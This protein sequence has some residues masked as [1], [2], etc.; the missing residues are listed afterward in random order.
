MIYNLKIHYLKRSNANYI[1]KLNYLPLS[2]KTA[3][4]DYSFP[5]QVSFGLVLLMILL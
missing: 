2:I 4:V 3:Q 5:N 1:D